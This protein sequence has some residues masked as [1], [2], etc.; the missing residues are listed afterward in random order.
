MQLSEVNP[1]MISIR[2]CE[3]SSIHDMYIYTH[4]HSSYIHVYMH[5]VWLASVNRA[6][7]RSCSITATGGLPPRFIR[8]AVEDSYISICLWSGGPRNSLLLP[9]R[10]CIRRFLVLC[11]HPPTH[12]SEAVDRIKLNKTKICNPYARTCIQN[13]RAHM[14]FIIIIMH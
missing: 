8:A 1:T 6:T 7:E 14:H 3:I 9:M 4:V 5:V 10:P 2:A 11:T 13:M 12:L